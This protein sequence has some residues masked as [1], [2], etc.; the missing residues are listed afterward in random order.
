MEHF[1]EDVQ[2]AIKDGNVEYL[3]KMFDSQFTNTLMLL[4]NGCKYAAKIGNLESLIFLHKKG[5]KIDY[6]I[7]DSLYENKSVECFKYV[8]DVVRPIDDVIE[9]IIDECITTFVDVLIDSDYCLDIDQC[10]NHAVSTWNV[11]MMIY[12]IEHGADPIIKGV[13]LKIDDPVSFDTL[14][15]KITEYKYQEQQPSPDLNDNTS[16]E[17]QCYS[18]HDIPMFK[19]EMHDDMNESN[20]TTPNV[21]D[22]LGETGRLVL[23]RLCHNTLKRKNILIENEDLNTVKSKYPLN[24]ISLAEYKKNKFIDYIV[25]DDTNKFILHYKSED[26]DTQMFALETI[27]MIGKLNCFVEVCKNGIPIFPHIVTIL[28]R[29]GHLECLKYVLEHGCQ[30]TVSAMIAAIKNKHFDCLQCLHEH[31]GPW[32]VTICDAAAEIG[33][34]E[35][36]QYVHLNGCPIGPELCISALKSKNQDCIDYAKMIMITPPSENTVTVPHGISPYV[37]DMFDS[38]DINDE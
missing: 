33:D 8:F 38:P 7:Y 9:R 24:M 14:R 2:C 10:M 29:E 5:C 34:I 1:N 13:T 36:L 27:A 15:K 31:H 3:Q 21:S 18:D 12:F 28:A 23:E 4:N 22:Y 26:H 30:I 6:T 37:D 16:E 32:D 17:E 25:S 20:N 11:K 35:Y 19:D